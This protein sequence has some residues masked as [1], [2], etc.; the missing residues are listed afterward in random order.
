MAHN[1]ISTTTSLTT[2]QLRGA[3]GEGGTETDVTSGGV[4]YRV[5]TFTSIGNT[6]FVLNRAVTG[7]QLLMVA[8]GGGGG[9]DNS[10]GGG[11]GGLAYYGT[12][13]PTNRTTPN[14]GNQSWNAGT[15]V[16]T[17]GDG[18]NGSPAVNQVA[19]NGD[20]S[21][22]NGPSFDETVT[23]GG[24]GGTG[25]AGNYDG[26]NGGSGGG[27]AMENTAGGIGGGNLGGNVGNERQGYNGGAAADNAGGGGGGAGAAGQA[28]D[29]RGDKLGG[30]GGVGLEYSISGSATFYAAGGNGGNENSIFNNG[31]RVNGIGGDTNGSGSTA[32]GDG[33]A[34]SGSGGGGVTHST[35]A[36]SAAGYY[37]GKGGSGIVIIRYPL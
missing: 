17:V 7:L 27:A 1:I 28:G 2:Y 10:G 15:Y 13:T 12:E 32:T 11:A 37:G 16:V 18:G 36:N 31:G 8:G 5:H 9:G 19:Q 35:S 14:G 3:A 34:N 20:N 22:V 6:N 24:L 4:T 26:G 30:F 33:V 29:V 21:R 23:G 25:N